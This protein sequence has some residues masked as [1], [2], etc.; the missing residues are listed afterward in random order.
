ML[1]QMNERLE[2]EQKTTC[3]NTVDLFL[4]CASNFIFV[5][6]SEHHY[7]NQHFFF[8]SFLNRYHCSLFAILYENDF[9][10][11]L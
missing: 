7:I 5:C 11:R 9:Q 2:L 6:L 3:W 4:I 10:I 1:F 8:L